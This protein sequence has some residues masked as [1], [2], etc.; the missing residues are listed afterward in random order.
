MNKL[1]IFNILILLFVFTSCSN[2]SEVSTIEVKQPKH[3]IVGKWKS[4]ETKEG[5]NF[6]IDFQDN[7]LLRVETI[8]A[9]DVWFYEYEITDD[10]TIKFQYEKDLAGHMM[11]ITAKII[12]EN[13][14]K[15]ECNYKEDPNASAFEDPP[16]LCFEFG[17]KRIQ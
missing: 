4:R 9:S 6:I 1:F 11:M 8:S 5:S 3:K 15:L 12:E 10:N 17:F 13:R 16:T 14:L 2:N 7:N